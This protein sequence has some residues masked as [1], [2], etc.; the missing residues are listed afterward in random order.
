[1]KNAIK[2]FVALLVVCAMA[3]TVSADVFT[4]SVEQKEAPAVVADETGNVGVVV[5]AEGEVIATVAATAIEITSVAKVEEAPAE[6]KEAVETAMAALEEAVAA[7]EEMAGMTITDVVYVG[8]S[9]AA[10]EEALENGGSIV[11]NFDL[12]VSPKANVKVMAF[13]DGAWV[14]LPADAVVVNEDG[15]VSVTVSQVG[16]YAFA[17]EK[18]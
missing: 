6:V 16:V 17:V 9:D 18:D 4:P 1:M 7:E 10:V 12:K 3:V 2:I 8:T 13:V 15:T 14:V 5:N 11:L